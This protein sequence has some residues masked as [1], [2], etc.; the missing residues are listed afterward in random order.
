[1]IPVYLGLVITA[2]I[3]ISMPLALFFCHSFLYKS[4]NS[5]NMDSEVIQTALK[6]SWKVQK[7]EVFKT[8]IHL[9]CCTWITVGFFYFVQFVIEWI[10]A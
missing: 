3:V 10:K 7:R 8:V 2:V 1:M 5:D 6:Q 9:F 4:I